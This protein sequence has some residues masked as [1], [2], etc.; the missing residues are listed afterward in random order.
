MKAV[1]VN[2]SESDIAQFSNCFILNPG[3]RNGSQKGL[4]GVLA[5]TGKIAVDLLF[6][7]LHPDGKG[8]TLTE[9]L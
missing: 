2:I 9:T 4:G 5:G 6:V 1:P 3:I 7:L 8:A